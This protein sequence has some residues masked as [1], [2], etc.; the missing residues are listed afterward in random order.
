MRESKCD[1]SGSGLRYLVLL[2]GDLPPLEAQHELGVLC[3]DVNVLGHLFDLLRQVPGATTEPSES[4]QKHVFN[5]VHDEMGG[6][7][8]EAQMWF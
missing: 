6:H 5:R 8:R 7:E 4:Y 1:P 2:Q 3:S